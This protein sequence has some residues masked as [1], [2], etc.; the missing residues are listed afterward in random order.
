MTFKDAINRQRI[1]QIVTHDGKAH[2]DEYLTC[3]LLLGLVP[4]A[5]LIRHTVSSAELDN[6]AVAVIDTGRIHDPDISCFDH[7]QADKGDQPKCSLTLVLDALGELDHARRV[8]PWLLPTEVLD[9]GGVTAVSRM[10]AAPRYLLDLNGTWLAAASPL[11][12]YLLQAFSTLTTLRRNHFMHELMSKCGQAMVCELRESHQRFA[13][14]D[15]RSVV[16]Q[17]GAADPL[18]FLW[19]DLP[20]SAHPDNWL[21]G[22]ARGLPVIPDMVVVANRYQPG[23]YIRFGVKLPFTTRDLAEAL[24]DPAKASMSGVSMEGLT[25]EK[26]QSALAT[27]V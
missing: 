9:S 11:E 13:L 10:M 20:S 14:L 19:V 26:L 25:P 22:Y 1:Y 2:R 12:K 18:A 5:S 4:S 15:Q 23:F 8:W 3:C 16:Y 21:T 6:P 7:H 17:V 27:F 24:G